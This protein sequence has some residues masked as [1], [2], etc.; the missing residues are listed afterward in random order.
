MGARQVFGKEMRIFTKVKPNSKKEEVK[1]IDPTHFEIKVSASP[2]EGQANQ[3]VIKV[4]T[5]YLDIPK[6]RLKIVLG[7]KS[8]HK[9]LEIN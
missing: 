1:Q 2:H 9:T 7:E 3:A 5:D 8:K 6:S 4:L